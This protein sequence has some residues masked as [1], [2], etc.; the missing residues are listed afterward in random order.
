MHSDLLTCTHFTQDGSSTV[1]VSLSN[2]DLDASDFNGECL[3]VLYIGLVASLL[4]VNVKQDI[5]HTQ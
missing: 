2:V 4:G 5:Q 1:S 3:C